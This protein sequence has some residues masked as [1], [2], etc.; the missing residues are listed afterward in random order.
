MPKTNVRIISLYLTIF[1][2]ELQIY[3]S[4]LYLFVYVSLSVLFVSR[5]SKKKTELFVRY[6]LWVYKYIIFLF[7]IPWWKGNALIMKC[8]SIYLLYMIKFINYCTYIYISIVTISSFL[9]KNFVNFFFFF[10]FK[11]FSCQHLKFSCF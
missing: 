11:D 4:E 8:L 5:N 3:I 6:K 9:L 1:F 10:T 7:F 2:S